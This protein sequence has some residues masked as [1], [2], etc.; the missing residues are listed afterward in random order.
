MRS[1][2]G[3]YGFFRGGLI[4]ESGRLPGDRLAPLEDRVELPAAW[5]FLLIRSDAPPGVSGEHEHAIFEE[6]DPVPREVT[7]ELRRILASTM[8]PAAK[9]ADFGRL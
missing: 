3:T 5:R 9:L 2:V 6:I 1:A 8:L 4:A 7:D